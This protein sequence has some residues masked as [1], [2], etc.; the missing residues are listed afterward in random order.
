M[1]IHSPPSVWHPSR[2]ELQT[3]FGALKGEV[4]HL[5]T[6]LENVRDIPM[7]VREF[8]RECRVEWERDYLAG[9]RARANFIR[10]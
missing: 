5:D 4:R 1:M 8:A 6:I 3:W 7:E 10:M 2:V 9:R